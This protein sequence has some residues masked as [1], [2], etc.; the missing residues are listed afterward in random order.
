MKKNFVF[1]LTVSATVLMMAG[2]KQMPVL[3][4]ASAPVVSPKQASLQ[5]VERSIMRAGAQLGWQLVP[6]GPG[7]IEGT[8]ALRTHKAVVDIT[9][10]TKAY[11]IKYKDSSNLNYDGS[12]IH[13]NYNGWIQNLDKG[14]RTQLSLL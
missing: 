3:N 9:Y 5:D 13:S 12:N 11:N 8:L 6:R 10:D 4:I 7:Q 14:I 1:W 2:C